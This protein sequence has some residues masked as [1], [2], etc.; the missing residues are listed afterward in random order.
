MPIAAGRYP[1]P[2]KVCRMNVK[3][4]WALT[5]QSMSSWS[6]DYAPSMGAALSYY[7]L[8]SIAPLLII[9]IAIAGLFF[10]ADAGR[11]VM[12]AK[13]PARLGNE[14]ATA[15]QDMLISA[16]KPSTGAIAPTVSI[17]GLLIGATT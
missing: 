7:T 10:C 12:L 4:A 16:S 17:V 14:S 2:R 15:I 3:Q 9:V 5:T 6:E 1:I 11:G 13:L 8:F